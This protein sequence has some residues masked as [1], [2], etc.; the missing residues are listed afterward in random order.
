MPFR[1]DPAVRRLGEN[2]TIMIPDVM[3]PGQCEKLI[4]LGTKLPPIQG[5]IADGAVSP[6]HRVS[7]ISWVPR[8]SV[9]LSLYDAIATAIF[10]INQAYFAYDLTVLEPMQFTT[11]VEE[12]QGF[13]DWHMDTGLNPAADTARKLSLTLQ[14]SDPAAYEGG[15]L[16]I[17]ADRGPVTAMKGQGLAVVFPAPTLHRVRPV[18]RGRRHSLVAWALGPRFR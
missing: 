2:Q 9:F 3:D 10:N 13:Y 17:W 5:V 15:D 7:T 16:E 12:V 14:L 8:E 18:M 6:V 4:E 11:Y 1:L